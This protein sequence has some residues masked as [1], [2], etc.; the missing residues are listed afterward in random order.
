MATLGHRLRRIIDR[1]WIRVGW[2]GR[3]T[4]RH[5][6]IAFTPAAI[7]LIPATLVEQRS[8]RTSAAALLLAGFF[9]YFALMVWIHVRGMAGLGYFSTI[10][11]DR[12]AKRHRRSPSSLSI[13]TNADQS[14]NGS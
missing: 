9:A 8:Y 12:V 14:A 11:S 1:D 5:H 10:R 2:V 3:P 7:L 6:L 4:L 13:P